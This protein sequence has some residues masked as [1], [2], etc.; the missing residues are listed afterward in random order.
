M[1]T[2][3][4]MPAV[5][6]IARPVAQF[7]G[8]CAGSAMAFAA[9]AWAFLPYE[10]L[11]RFTP[12]ARF[13]AW[14]GVVWLFALLL[15]FLGLTCVLQVVGGRLREGV[16]ELLRHLSGEDTNNPVEVVA[17]VLPWWMMA[18]GGFLALIGVLARAAIAP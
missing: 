11:E 12:E 2:S 7:F 16:G 10:R 3:R 17:A 9:L 5:R 4:G 14:E 18:C 15:G 13:L 8:I 6:V 1:Y